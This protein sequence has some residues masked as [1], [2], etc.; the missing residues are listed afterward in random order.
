MAQSERR[1]G[2]GKHKAERREDVAKGGGAAVDARRLRYGGLPR[3]MQ[4]CGIAADKRFEK[5]ANERK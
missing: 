5:R 3:W 1:R 4:G 2:R